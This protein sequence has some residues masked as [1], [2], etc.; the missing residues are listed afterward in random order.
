[1]KE[2][3]SSAAYWDRKAGRYDEAVRRSGGLVQQVIAAVKPFLQPEIR[4]LDA[5]A[6]TGAL[7]LPLAKE[8]KELYLSDLAPGMVAII[9]REAAQ[10][11]LSNVHVSV[12]DLCRLPYP[13]AFFDV[14]MVCAA[15]HL[16]PQPEKAMA[17]IK[18]VLKPGGI[19]V[20][21][22]YLAH[23][24]LVSRM[25][26][27]LMSLGGYRDTQKWDAKGFL[28][29]VTGQGFDLITSQ[30]LPIWPIP[31]LLVTARLHG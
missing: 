4:M 22:A 25:G 9:Q 15:L 5:A 23:H 8:L 30:H 13:D 12:Q 6:G 2:K 27:G 19:F 16:L 14:A 20:A 10:R 7:S 28:D 1:M 31:A 18:R 26:N 17:E 3:K 24:G 11:K 29:F 21:S